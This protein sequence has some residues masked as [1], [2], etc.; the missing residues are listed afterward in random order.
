MAPLMINTQFILSLVKGLGAI[1]SKLDTLDIFFLLDESIF[2][3]NTLIKL[4]LGKIW[5]HQNNL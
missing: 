1:M 3:L 4:T 2:I 5:T